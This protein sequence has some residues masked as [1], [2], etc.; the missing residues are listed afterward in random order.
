MK[1]GNILS[2]L[3]FLALCLFTGAWMGLCAANIDVTQPLNQF[4]REALSG[5]G[6]AVTNHKVA[7]VEKLRAYLEEIDASKKPAVVAELMRHSVVQ[8]ST[9]LGPD[10]RSR[11]GRVGQASGVLMDEDGTIITNYHVVSGARL[12]YVRL[13]DG[14]VFEAELV[15]TDWRTDL[16]VLRLKPGKGGAILDLVP[17]RLGDS[18]KMMVA[19]KVLAIGN[20]YGLS[21][22]VT[23]GIISAKGRSNIGIADLEN[24]IQTD[25]AINPGNSGGPLVN[26]R[27]EVIGINT[28][29][30][31][32]T[33][34][35]SG[36]S[37]AIPI[38]MV[39]EIKK[40]LVANGRVVRG[41]LGISVSNV[42]VFR[43]RSMGL[44]HT[45]GALLIYVEPD[46]PVARAGL[47][48]GDF[49]IEF[50]GEKIV[51][52]P[53]LRNKVAFAEIGSTVKIKYLREG[54]EHTA[55][56][57]IVEEPRPETYTD[58][59]LGIVLQQLD[60]RLRKR[61]KYGDRDSGIVIVNITT[62]NIPISEGVIIHEIV[63]I[64]QDTRNTI[65]TLK[66]YEK[67]VQSARSGDKVRIE[68]YRRL[69]N[70]VQMRSNFVTV[71]P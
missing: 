65:G 14:R 49:I 21:Q 71:I 13:A 24:F 66:D 56:V 2:S 4:T 64:T 57:L 67:A 9:V 69:P 51:D 62:G 10:T 52:V 1:R 48:T 41:Y 36:I 23:E 46:S 59:V 28:A 30:I 29:I 61:F 22:T 31:S 6:V 3:I 15:G 17:A 58:N 25:A 12:I 68:W 43:A 35:Y 20:P 37:F 50:G 45:R 54:K 16:A 60:N 8:V 55:E 42:N 38:K 34:S 33:G 27:G 70:G 39:N 44:P 53:A 32:R 26:L 18:D 11:G 47:K 5:L 40:Q 63:N 19:E 7:S